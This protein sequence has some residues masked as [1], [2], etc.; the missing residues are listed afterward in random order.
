MARSGSEKRQRTI[1]K[2]YRLTREEAKEMKRRAEHAAISEAA[3]I[4]LRCLDAKPPRQ[5]PH[6]TV[7]HKAVAQ[8]IGHLGKVGSNLNQLARYA[9]SDRLLRNSIRLACQE[10]I[11][12][13][14]ACMRALGRKP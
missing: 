13:R 8:L 14:A 9:H 5:I 2:S 3:F 6:P 1:M 10:I 4:R 11:V 7:N 12:M